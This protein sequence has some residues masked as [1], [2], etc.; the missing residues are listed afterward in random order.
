MIDYT[1]EDVYGTVIGEVETREYYRF[2]QNGEIVWDGGH[3]WTDQEAIDAFKVK[4]P[5]RKGIEMRVCK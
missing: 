5:D 2:Y 4:F 3:F 1:I